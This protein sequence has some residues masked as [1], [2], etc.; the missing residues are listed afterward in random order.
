MEYNTKYEPKTPKPKFS[1]K[2]R[3]ETR[4]VHNGLPLVPGSTQR[5]IESTIK[6]KIDSPRSGLIEKIQKAALITAAVAVIGVGAHLTQR[7]YFGREQTPE[8]KIENRLRDNKNMD[9]VAA[10]AREII[11]RKYFDGSN[12]TITEDKARQAFE[13]LS[14]DYPN[15]LGKLISIHVSHLQGV[16]EFDVGY[17]MRLKNGK[18]GSFSA[19]SVDR[20]QLLQFIEKN[21]NIEK[22]Q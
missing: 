5:G 15:N 13:D 10:K 18:F 17:T 20:Y 16:N 19:G 11:K 21:Q 3:A 8:Q 12:G 7:G 1:W 14:I 22:Y 2:P 6:V 4:E 9:A